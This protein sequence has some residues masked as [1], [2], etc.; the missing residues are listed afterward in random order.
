MILRRIYNPKG[1]IGLKALF[2]KELSDYLSSNRFFLL[3]LLI[4]SA[5]F[6]GIYGSSKGM[7]D[8]LTKENYFLFLK[9]FTISSNSIPSFMSF[10]TLLGPILGLS[11][12][13]DSINSERSC[14]TLNRLVSQPIYR[15]A[16]ILGKFGSGVTAITIIVYS[17]GIL[18]GTVS[19]ITIGI[20]PQGEE[21]IRFFIFLT[22]AIIYISYWLAISILFS[23]VCR[24][25]TTSALASIGTW[26]FFSFFMNIIANI[27]SNIIYPIN[28]EYLALYNS[29]NNYTLRMNLNRISPS[30]LFTEAISTIMNPSI[31][32]VNVVTTNQLSGAI[33][34]YLSLDQSILLIWPHL[35]GIIALMLVTFSIA[36]IVFMRQEIRSN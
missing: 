7:P 3:L 35:T 27:I 13:F 4:G 29:L 1:L 11:L 14:G 20:A 36:Y 31:R 17:I 9:M 19:I 33:N 34:G 5:A 12:G 16:I 32:S 18:A 24:N 23:V 8:I 28:N 30:Y 2:F 10:I 15:D 26:L 21:L 6:A 22:F 25:S